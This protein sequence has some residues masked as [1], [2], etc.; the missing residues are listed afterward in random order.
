MSVTYSL[1]GQTALVTGGDSGIGRGVAIE[2]AGA[3][4]SVMVNYAHNKEAAEEVVKIIEDRGGAAYA[5]QADVSKEPD[6]QSMFA[7]TLQRYGDLDILINNAGLQ[8]DAPLL[9]MTLQ[10]WQKVIDINLTGQFLC[11]REAAKVFVKRGAV[12]GRSS[13]A[14]KIICM[15][16]VHQVIPWAG[17]INYA[18]SK[19]GIMMLMKTLAQ[20]LA[21]FKIRVLAIAP[22]AIQTPINEDA[23]STKE[24]LQKLLTLIPYGRI[25]QP[26]DIGKLAAWAAS[27]EADYI[28][29]TTLFSDGGMALYPGF[30][31]NG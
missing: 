23:W 6:V 29:G 21:P 3:G 5:R 13:A 14:G 11:A 15:S 19:G 10:Q 2:L 12:E 7:E 22:G 31:D 8:Q 26:A 18:S 9:E 17:H 1:K 16:S 25:G 24:A 30:A 28:T 20:E 4:A 27:D